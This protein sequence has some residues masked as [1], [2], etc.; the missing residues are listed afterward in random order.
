MPYSVQMLEPLANFWLLV[1]QKSNF[2]ALIGTIIA[3]MIDSLQSGKYI[4][5]VSGGVDSVVLLNMLSNRA[6]LELTVAHYD[7][8]I[9]IDSAEDERFVANLALA[10]T[11]PYMSAHGNLGP[12]TS[13]AVAREKRYTFLRQAQSSVGARAIIIA[14]HQDDM[15]ETVILNL[16]RGTNRKGLAALQSGPDLVRPLLEVSKAEILTYATDHGLEWREDST[17]LDRKYLRNYIRHELLPRFDQKSRQKLLDLLQQHRAT[18]GE[19][20]T[21]LVKYL[22]GQNGAELNRREFIRLPHNVA[23]EVLAAWLRAHDLRDFD[24]KT[25]E[26]LVI[27]AKTG[28]PG[29]HFPILKGRY[30]SIQK[31]G[32]ALRGPER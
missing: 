13:E 14:H 4:V 16:L 5:A 17:N 9:R 26:R 24:R 15:L 21:L 32:L 11:L 30:L 25:L 31:N 23:K 29:Q 3:D 10:H 22:A 7:H 18:S 12:E 8:G 20:D 6:G 28:Q 2:S 19:I 1:V 27:A